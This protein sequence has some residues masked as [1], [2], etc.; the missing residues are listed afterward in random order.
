[1]V[2]RRARV[3]MLVGLLLLCRGLSGWVVCEVEVGGE[4]AAVATQLLW[5]WLST[6]QL[7][8]LKYPEGKSSSLCSERFLPARKLLYIA[9]FL[10]LIHLWGAMTSLATDRLDVES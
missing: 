10:V 2:L 3:D 5:R 4:C 9:S 6:G 1:M 8:L 7:G